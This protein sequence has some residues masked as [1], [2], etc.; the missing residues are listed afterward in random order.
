MIQTGSFY[1][2]AGL[3]A[4]VDSSFQLWLQGIDSAYVHGSA[5]ASQDSQ[6]DKAALTQFYNA[7]GGVNWENN[8]NWLSNQPIRTWHGVTNDEDGRVIG[9]YL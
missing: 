2:N 9:L 7:T 6:G 4:P 8:S 3:C 5:C 1:S